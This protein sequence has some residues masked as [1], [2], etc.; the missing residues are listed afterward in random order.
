MV[1]KKLINKLTE[2]NIPHAN[3]SAANHVTV[4]IGI[5]SGKAEYGLNAEEYIKF[6]D[7]LL[8]RSKAEGRNR[9]TYEPFGDEDN[10]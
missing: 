10:G 2:R 7:E 5:T 6:A 3:N 9:Y 1:A 8:Y 4:S